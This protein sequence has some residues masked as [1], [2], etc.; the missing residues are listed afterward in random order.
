M[1]NA[2]HIRHL[3]ESFYLLAHNENHAHTRR[4]SKPALDAGL[5]A[6]MLAE[7]WLYRRIG[8][9]ISAGQL[10][11]GVRDVSPPECPLAHEVLGQLQQYK[12]APVRSWLDALA[13]DAG[14]RVA[15]KMVRAEIL[16]VVQTGLL[17]R[18]RVYVPFD[19]DENCAITA[20]VSGAATNHRNLTL[21][22]RILLGLA[23]QTDL[24]RVLIQD[25]PHRMDYVR[26]QLQQ[27]PPAMTWLM[28]EFAA[29]IGAVAL[30]RT[31]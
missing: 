6:A 24:G 8:F 16:A 20:R 5:A 4:L 29:V 27:L 9:K 17:R 1:S 22:D 23:E 31:R 14:D 7:L 28:A 11:L 21:P 2:H 12:V 3:E 26:F 10:V 15:E 25:V 19:P 13:V 18:H 30:N